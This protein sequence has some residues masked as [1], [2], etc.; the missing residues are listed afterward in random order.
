LIAYFTFV[1]VVTIASLRYRVPIE[2]F[3]LVL[4]ADS[5]ALAFERLRGKG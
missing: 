5:L 2:P 3:F 1:H 4:G